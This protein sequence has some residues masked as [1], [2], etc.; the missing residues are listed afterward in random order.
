[1][2][3]ACEELG[4]RQ[5]VREPTRKEKTTEKEYLLDLVLTDLEDVKCVV[6]AGVADHKLVVATLKLAVPVE[7]TVERTVWVFDKAD[8]DALRTE[9]AETNWD[10]LQ[11]LGADKAAQTA[12]ERVLE[13]LKKHVPTYG[14]GE[15]PSSSSDDE[16]LP[17]PG[18]YN[19]PEEATTAVKI[20]PLPSQKIKPFAKLAMARRRR[21]MRWV[22]RGAASRAARGRFLRLGA[23]RGGR[24]DS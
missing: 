16:V 20:N 4:L 12:T 9:L 6:E 24:T 21:R 10:S 5:Q 22:R 15:A 1:M 3:R 19:Q 13:A 23:R 18:E 14:F 17:G 7:E 11:E 8:W 2:Q